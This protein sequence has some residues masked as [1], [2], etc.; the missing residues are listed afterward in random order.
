VKSIQQVADEI[1]KQSAG[2]PLAEYPVAMG[3]IRALAGGSA[4]GFLGDSE[5][6]AHIRVILAAL[7]EVQ[8][9]RR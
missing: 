7:D 6:L 2:Y 1:R 9:E 8:E 3:M 4:A 5:R